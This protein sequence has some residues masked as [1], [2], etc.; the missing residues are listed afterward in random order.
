MYYYNEWYSVLELKMHS[1]RCH[2]LMPRYAPM[3]PPIIASPKREFSGIRHLPF[4]ALYLSMPYI[5]KV[6]IFIMTII[7]EIDSS[8]KNYFNCLPSEKALPTRLPSST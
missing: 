7:I 5:M 2:T 1:F 6:T 3:L 4:L 8:I